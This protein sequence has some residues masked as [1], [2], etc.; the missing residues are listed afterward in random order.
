[1]AGG[2]NDF[3]VQLAVRRKGDMDSSTSEWTVAELLKR[4]A[5]RPADDA[6]W[7]EFVRRYHSTIR[8]NVMKTFHRKA[9]EDVDRK[10]QFPEDLVEDLVQAV[11]MRL[12][13]DSNRAL[14][15]FEGEHENSIYNYLS[16]ISINVVRDHFRETRAQKRPKVSFSLDELIEQSGDVAF[17]EDPSARP[18]NHYWGPAATAPTMED[19]EQALKRCVSGKNRERDT[20]IFKLRFYQ[21]LTLDEITQVMGLDISP[22]SV[23]SILNRILKRLRPLL[24]LTNGNRARGVE[25][26][27]DGRE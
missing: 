17:L 3:C 5:A 15:R 23:G 6:A 27:S 24:E 11:Y 2:A 14:E 12:V 25:S 16:I 9:R 8:A 13:E 20:L 7:H 10:P 26:I 19:I 1:M 21:G 22:I 4:C 18:N